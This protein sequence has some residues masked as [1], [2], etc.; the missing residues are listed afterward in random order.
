M[1]NKQN[2]D[3]KKEQTPDP[4]LKQTQIILRKILEK[5]DISAEK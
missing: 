2:K 4:D 1:D 5:L 3:P